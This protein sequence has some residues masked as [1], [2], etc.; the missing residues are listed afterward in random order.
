MNN[1]PK[2][3]QL[4]LTAIL[5]EPTPGSLWRLRADI[6]EHNLKGQDILLPILDHFYH[7][8]NELVASSTA[9]E[10]SH[11]ASILDMAAVAGVAIQNL[12]E[13]QN[14]EDWWRRFV[15][16]AASEGLMVMAA[17]QYVKAWEEEMQAS[18]HAAAWYLTQEYWVLSSELKPDLPSAGRRILIDRLAASLLD[19]ELEG[20]VK[21]GLIV[22]LFQLL[23]LAR[24]ALLGLSKNEVTNK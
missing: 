9:R 3:L 19:E 5:K 22:R 4:S 15:L 17:R 13:E 10:Y 7:F 20:I 1:I 14:S 23:L 16:G 21:A 18:Y 24:F 2:Q 11:F 12:M 6:L 8:L